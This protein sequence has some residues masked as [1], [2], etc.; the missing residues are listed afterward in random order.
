MVLQLPF[1]FYL[2]L[3]DLESNVLK[4]LLDLLSYSV[5]LMENGLFLNLYFCQVILY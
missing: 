3:N 4:Q 1:E 5:S 2:F